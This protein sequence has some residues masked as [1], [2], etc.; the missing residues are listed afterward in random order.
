MRTNGG[1]RQFDVSSPGVGDPRV[2]RRRCCRAAGGLLA[3]CRQDMHDAPRYDPLEDERRCF[4]SGSSA[5]PLVD[6]TVARGHLNDDELLY[7][8]KVERPAGRRVSVPDHARGSRPRRGALQHLLLALPRPDRRRQRHGRAA[9]LPAGRRRTTST[10]CAQAP[11]GLFL[12]RDDERL[13]RDAG[14]PV[15]DSGRRIGG[16]SSR[17][18]A[19]CS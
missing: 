17:T 1:S 8:G 3:G 19:R 4:P 18:S 14:L 10:G 11:V 2:A 5:Q 9:R 16:A 12:R 6:G 15:A 13:R 7:T